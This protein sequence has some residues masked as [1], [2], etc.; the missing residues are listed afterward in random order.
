MEEL[1]PCSIEVALKWVEQEIHDYCTAVR[2]AR[3]ALS[4]LLR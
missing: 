3:A 1:K 4:V 2:L